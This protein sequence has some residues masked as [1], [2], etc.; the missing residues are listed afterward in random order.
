MQVQ[1]EHEVKMKT[2]EDLVDCWGLLVWHSHYLLGSTTQKKHLL[3]CACSVYNKSK[4][5]AKTVCHEQVVYSCFS[6]LCLNK[7]LL[8]TLL[9]ILT[10]ITVSSS[11]L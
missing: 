10:L 9:L 2:H 11:S 6:M 7:Q 5:R 4:V 8:I 1:Q 3:V